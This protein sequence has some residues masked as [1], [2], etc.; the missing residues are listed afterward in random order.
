MDSCY[1]VNCFNISGRL[2]YAAAPDSHGK[3]VMI[4]SEK[5]KEELIWKEP[6]GTMSFVAIPGKEGE[7]LSVQNFFPG[8]DSRHTLLVW[9]KR[10]DELGWIIKPLL[11]I[12]YIHRFDIFRMG[13][14]N[15]LLVCTL[16]TN[17]DNINDWTS[18]GEVWAGILPEDPDN[19]PDMEV[20]LGGL[21]KNHGYCRVVQD[22]KDYGLAGCDNG[23]FEI[24]PPQNTE[25]SWEI[26]Q[27]ADF[28]VS[29]VAVCDIDHD[30]KLEYMTIEP[31]HGNRFVIYKRNGKNF[32]KIWEYQDGVEFGHVVWGG[33]FF[34]MPI[35]IGGFREGNAELF[36]VFPDQKQ[37][38]KLEKCTL[39]DGQGPANVCVI[40][41]ED[42]VKILTSNHKAGELVLYELTQ[43]GEGHAKDIK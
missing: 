27:I 43:E 32:T 30:N 41:E 2:F 35:F 22:G 39:D 33:T 4:D 6:G 37:R 3:A 11:H 20:I 42:K 38:D 7:F 1:A 10:H 26:R 14:V 19:T 40:H 9:C 23:I 13:R 28:P 31:F 24:Y 5:E 12:P 16:C 17:K 21:T 15:Y 29:D 18:P 8:F 25:D 34:G 36:C